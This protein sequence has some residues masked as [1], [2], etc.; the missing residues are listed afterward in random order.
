MAT[1]F[2]L[3]TNDVLGFSYQEYLN[4]VRAIAIGKPQEYFELRSAVMEKVKRDAVKNL[5]E[6]LF[7]VLSTGKDS[8]GNDIAASGGTIKLGAGKYVPSY[9]TQKINDLVLNMAHK[10]GEDLSDVI[11]IILPDD[12][13]KLAGAKLTIQGRSSEIK[14]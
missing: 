11:D 13:D 14:T 4:N 2:K 12:F 9:P 10:L 5:Y 3:D 7:A 1:P 6:T 8:A